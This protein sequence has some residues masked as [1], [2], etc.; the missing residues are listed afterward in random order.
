MTEFKTGKEAE[1]WITGQRWKGEKHGLENTLALLNALGNPEKRIGKIVHVAGTNGKGSTCAFIERGLRECGYNTGLFTSPYLCSFNERIMFN[2]IPIPDAELASAASIV[3]EK[4][5]A[6]A[7]QGIRATTFE[8]LTA[9]GCVYFAKRQTDYAVIEVGLGGRLDSTNVLMPAVSVIA[10]I[11]MDHMQILGNT[12][13]EIAQEKAGIIKPG[14]PAVVLNQQESVME[15]FRRAARQAS[16]PLFEVS[17]IQT[18]GVSPSGGEFAIA[19]PA[20]GLIKQRISISGRHQLLNAALAL[21]ALDRLEIDLAAA[22]AGLSKARWPGRLELIGNVLID[23]SHNP[24]GAETLRRF[25]DEFYGSKNKVLLTGMMQDKQLEACSDIFASF[26]DSVVTTKVD[27]PRAAEPEALKAYYDGRIDNV[28]ACANVN[29]AL[30]KARELAGSDGLIVAAGS[31]YI[32]GAVRN[33]L[34]ES[35]GVV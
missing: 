3:R 5:E 24:Q 32:A 9:V 16:A 2:G 33:L 14:I 35:S 26:A 18:I 11:G 25:V 7:N 20:Y 31:V 12:I 1:A 22:S 6:L 28:V 21:T 19:L 4:A 13:E 23:C 8:L 10:A 34:T 30:K 27:W 29:E 17:P 15:V